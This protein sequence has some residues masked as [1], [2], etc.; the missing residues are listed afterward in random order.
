MLTPALNQIGT[1]S[2]T[3]S[4]QDNTGVSARATFD[5]IVKG[6]PPVIVRQPRDQT[7][8]A[9][10]P[11]TFD[12]TVVGTL[13]LEYQW[14]FN[15]SDL[16]GATRSVLELPGVQLGNAGVYSVAVSNRVGA[17]AS[18]DA[19]LTVS[20]PVRITQP[21]ASQHI[22]LGAEASSRAVAV[23]VPPLSYQCRLNASTA[24]E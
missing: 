14:R 7:V 3:A 17:L 19:R 1:V 4:V 10:T 23:G 13:P 6:R 15:G 18:A 8:V 16:E 22:L 11:A 20:V 21:P 24:P 9:D 5:L 12:V 2:V